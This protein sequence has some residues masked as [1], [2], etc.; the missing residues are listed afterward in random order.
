MS[1]Y[2]ITTVSTF[3]EVFNTVTKTTVY[4]TDTR[5]KAVNIC[6]K[7]NLGQINEYNLK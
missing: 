4:A 7:L 5:S 1:K 3:F 2:K 6:N